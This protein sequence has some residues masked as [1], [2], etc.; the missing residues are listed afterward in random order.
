MTASNDVLVSDALLEDKFAT[1]L[2]DYPCLYDVRSVDF[3][4]RDLRQKAMEG[5]GSSWIRHLFRKCDSGF[6]IYLPRL[7]VRHVS[8]GIARIKNILKQYC[9]PY[10]LICP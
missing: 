7:S 6:N 1:I 8:D 2:P 5:I 4:N 3:R 10:I 9:R